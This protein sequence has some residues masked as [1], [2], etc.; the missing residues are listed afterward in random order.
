MI[1]QKLIALA[2]HE[3]IKDTGCREIRNLIQATP[4]QWSRIVKMIEKLS[5]TKRRNTAFD[6]IK[7]ALTAFRPV[8][9]NDYG[10]SI[11]PP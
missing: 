1:S 6:V 3:L 9:L 2:I 8:D 5:F 7:D 10:I 4:M 11:K